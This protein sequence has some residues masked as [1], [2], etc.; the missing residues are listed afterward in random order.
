MGGFL[1]YTSRSHPPKKRVWPPLTDLPSFHSPF[2]KNPKKT[3][4]RNHGRFSSGVE[5]GDTFPWDC[6]DGL[7][8]SGNDNFHDTPASWDWIESPRKMLEKVM[9]KKR[10]CSLESI[11]CCK[12]MEF[13]FR[14]SRLSLM[15]PSSKTNHK[16]VLRKIPNMRFVSGITTSTQS[17]T[18]IPYCWLYSPVTIVSIISPL[19]KETLNPVV[20]NEIM[21]INNSPGLDLVS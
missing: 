16:W 1:V 13:F 10:K 21:V 6:R 19:K 8:Q 3:A 20:H 18:W 4:S 2:P 15:W 11:W 17:Q 5:N 12:T 14:E 7:E 9:R